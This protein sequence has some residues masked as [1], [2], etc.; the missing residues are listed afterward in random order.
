VNLS[1][2]DIGDGGIVTL[3]H[4]YRAARNPVLKVLDVS[5]NPFGDSGGRALLS[6]VAHLSSISTFGDALSLPPKLAH[7][8]TLALQAKLS[9][10]H[11]IDANVP[12]GAVESVLKLGDIPKDSVLLPF[13]AATPAVSSQLYCWDKPFRIM[14]RKLMCSPLRHCEWFTATQL[15]V[16]RV[17]VDP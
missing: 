13:D 1:N 2:N 8:I 10:L 16:R 12:V 3:C 4:C 11:S 17:S 15:G 7:E 6:V 9:P 5:R 14:V